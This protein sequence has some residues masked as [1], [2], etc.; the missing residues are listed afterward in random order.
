MAAIGSEGRRTSSSSRS[1][2]GSGVMQV[3]PIHRR[4]R[5]GSGRPS[6]YAPNC[7]GDQDELLWL[8]DSGGDLISSV[9][10][11]EADHVPPHYILSR[12]GA[13]PRRVKCRKSRAARLHILPRWFAD[14]APMKIHR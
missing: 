5:R 14:A 11:E 4:S 7:D 3:W 2:Q 12:Q 10:D 13:S 1:K 9:P 6:G 8:P